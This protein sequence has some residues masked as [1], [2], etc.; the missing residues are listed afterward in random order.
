MALLA[1][2]VSSVMRT[3]VP[4]VSPEAEIRRVT[5]VML[6]TGLPG[7]PVADGQGQVLGFISRSDILRAVVA[8][9]P[10]E[11]WA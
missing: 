9:P 11:L 2:P 6:D 7:L 3:P 1:Q 4:C 10:L 5:L 8:E